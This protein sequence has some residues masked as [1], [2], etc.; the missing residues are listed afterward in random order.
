[1]H[2]VQPMPP[3]C[4]YLATEQPPEGGADVVVVAGLVVEVVSVVGLA[5]VVA[6]LEVVVVPALVVVVGLGPPALLPQLHTA[7]PGTV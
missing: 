3:H 1:M 6:G 2:P 5:V 7:G 4:P